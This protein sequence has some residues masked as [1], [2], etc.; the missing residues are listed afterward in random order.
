MEKWDV[1]FAKMLKDKK[2]NGSFGVTTGKIISA[3]PDIVV[4]VG[5]EI[6][7]D[8]SD[9]IIAN[10]LYYMHTH[11]DDEY[12][13]PIPITLITGDMVI[14]IPSSNGQTYYLIDKVGE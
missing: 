12:H 2:S 13:T 10:R 4:Q 3:L 11:D 6:L 1:G 9:L 8:S 7:L 5:D 14:L